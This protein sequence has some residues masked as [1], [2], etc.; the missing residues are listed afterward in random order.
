MTLAAVTRP[1]SR[2]PR[3][4]IVAVVA[5]WTACSPRSGPA[6]APAPQA[7]PRLTPDREFLQG[8]FSDVEDKLYDS[9][10]AYFRAINRQWTM[11]ACAEL[12]ADLSPFPRVH[13]HGDAHVGQYTVTSD[14][15]GLD[16]FDDSSVGPA[17]V[18]LIRFLASIELV[19]RERGWLDE[20]DAVSE[21]FARGYRRGLDDPSYL[22]P[23]PAVVTRLRARVTRPPQEFLAWAESLMRP[24]P[25]DERQDVER[26]FRFFR[27]HA[28]EQMPS[29][30]AGYF[31]AKRLGRLRIGIGS[32]NV[33]KTLARVEGPTPASGD[34][35]ILELKDVSS[36]GAGT[37]VSVNPGVEAFRP[38][39]AVWQLG[40]VRSRVLVT[41]P[42]HPAGRPDVPG[43]WVRSWDPTYQELTIADLESPSEL[44]EVAEDAGAQL[45]ANNTGRA[46]SADRA[47]LRSLERAS[48]G[49][50]EA[51]VRSIARKLAA[52]LVDAWQVFRAA[53][54]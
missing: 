45:G 17:A 33:Y 41:V 28:A 31:T 47:A 54:R 15:R 3:I 42:H 40:R 18:D 43:F 35:V 16:D 8:V 52:E 21:A 23:D 48:F 4:A 51:R 30:S 6:T 11:A 25:P 22:P 27:E 37:C 13:L 34:D 1:P 10:F 12:G 39:D 32:F 49:R 24:I 38:A 5:A 46:T 14:A 26:S 44:V 50:A 19:A 53:R 29:L 7:T 2:L 9:A 20:L 36:L